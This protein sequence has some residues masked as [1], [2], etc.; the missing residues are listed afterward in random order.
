M[1]G[2]LRMSTNEALRIYNSFSREV[3]SKENRK[4]IHQDGSF[5][6]T[7]LERKIQDIVSERNLGEFL[8]SPLEQQGESKAFVCAIAASD[9]QPRLF[10]TYRVRENPSA[11]CRIWEAARATSAAPTFFKRISIGEEGHPMEEFIDAAVGY[12][13]PANLVLEEAKN[14]FGSAKPIRCVVSVGTGHP[15][16]VG[17]ARPDAFQKILPTKLIQV[18]K[19]TATECEQTASLISKRFKDFEDFYFRFNVEHGAEGVSLEEWNKMGEMQGFTKTYLSNVSVTKAIDSVVQKLFEAVLWID[20]TNRLTIEQSYKSIAIAQNLAGMGRDNLVQQALSWL[21]QSDQEW[22]LLFDNCESVEAIERLLPDGDRGNILFTSRN[23]ELGLAVQESISIVEFEIE[24]AVTLLLKA[25]KK[26]PEDERLRKD[27]KPIV[28]SLGY[29]PLAIDIAGASIY[30][31]RHRL[32]DYVQTLS[33]HRRAMMKDSS[34]KGSSKYNQ[35]V[36]TVWDISYEALSL[37]TQGREDVRKAEAALSAMHIL[38]LS[39]YFHNEAIMEEIFKRAAE[40]R[41]LSNDRRARYRIGNSGDLLRLF[42]LDKTGIWDSYLFRMGLSMLVSFSLINQDQ[43]GHYFSVHTL[44]HSWARDRMPQSIEQ[45]QHDAAIAVLAS[46]ITRGHLT[47][48]YAFRRQLLPHI[49]TCIQYSTARAINNEEKLV[50]ASNFALVYGESGY[51]KEAED[52]QMQLMETRSRVLG[53]EHPDTLT[54]QA[55]L[56]A[57][58][59]NQGRWKE[60]EKLGLQVIQTSKQVLGQ[61]HLHT[62]I[63][64]AN[65]ATTYWNQGRW[66]EAE[67]LEVQVMETSVRALGQEHL[68]TLLSQANLAA[69][70]QNQGRWKEAEGL[71]EKVMETRKQVLGQ[72][73]PHTL[74]SQANLASVYLNQ[75]RWKESEELQV[76]VM[77]TRKQV[78]GQEHPHTLS[79]Q[80]D[81]AAAYWNQG[82]WKE[83][84]ELGAKVMEIRTRVLGQEHPDTLVS[85]ANRAVTYLR[86]GRHSEALV[87]MRQCVELS[88]RTLGEEHPHT[89]ARFTALRKWEEELNPNTS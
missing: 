65:L 4:W 38:G 24:D 25:A 53:H 14:V 48:D 37:A 41:A 86:Q 12:N 39:A 40:S 69:T 21:S 33:Q 58:F 6:A 32:N 60:A 81:L 84:E 62:L 8:L 46:S 26:D 68:Y 31:G 2:R 29:L 54:T 28:E 15:G 75:G 44:I 83:A 55:N 50:D 18:L 30:M 17:L 89:Q 63:S 66:K 76:Q 47:E 13:N 87:L 42:T 36:Y 74:I 5:K 3:F 78:L 1:L 67:E 51:W 88:L 9:L 70:Y 20:A 11:N 49:K 80:A 10:R 43:S 82:R 52:L 64:Q 79:S 56:A 19:Q 22:L 45:A 16:T 85:Q 34:F 57:T 7:T 59:L 73:H 23:P 35:A 27:A 72:E 71:G 61:E 77:K